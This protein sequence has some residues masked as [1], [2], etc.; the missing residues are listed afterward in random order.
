MCSSDLEKVGNYLEAKEYLQNNELLAVGFDA[1]D[2]F[3]VQDKFIIDQYL[4]TPLK[5]KS[6]K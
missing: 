4:D 3:E 6:S 5:L 2:Q 1:L